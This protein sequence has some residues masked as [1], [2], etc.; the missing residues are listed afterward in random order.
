MKINE[1]FILREIADTYLVVAVGS[2]VKEFNGVIT[3]NQT[4]AFLWK[5]LEKGADEQSLVSALLQEYEVSEAQAKKDVVTFIE[6]LK[7]ANLI[8]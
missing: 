3:L 1:G 8:K 4:G 2:A 6:K 7:G 5:E